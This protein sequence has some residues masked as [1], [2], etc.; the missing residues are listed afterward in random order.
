M[1]KRFKIDGFNRLFAYTEMRLIDVTLL[2]MGINLFYLA[3]LSLLLSGCGDSDSTHYQ[4]YVEGENI[5]LA[6]P[7]S[8]ILVDKHVQRGQFVKAGDLLFKLDDNPQALVVGESRASLSQA[9]EIY[10]D[11]IKPRR[12][13]EIDAI[14]AQVEQ[15][16]SQLL[17]AQ[18]RVKRYQELYQKHAVDK[19]TLDASVE[20]LNELTYLKSQYQ[21][22]LA[23]AKLGSRQ[24][25]VKAQRAQVASLRFKLQKV[26]WE[27]QQKQIY[28]PADGIIFDTY[29]EQGEFVDAAHPIA[30]LLTPSNI[31][32]QFFVPADGLP[33]LQLGQHINFDCDGCRPHN[34]AVIQYIS[35]EAEYVPPLVYSREN[36]DNLVFRVKADIKDAAQFKPGQPVM[37][38]VLKHD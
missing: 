34:K 32:I 16:N 13:P 3:I 9:K 11:L 14:T 12:A 10:T 27:M 18:L 29:F 37:V 38:S 4:G 2:S 30:A 35:P 5:Y 17:L 21:A 7:Y 8:G 26:K 25:Q 24:Y 23:L 6:S 22:N 1:R 15:T 19:D 20:R 31:R 36:R 28:A 33:K